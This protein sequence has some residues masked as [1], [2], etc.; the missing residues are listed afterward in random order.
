MEITSSKG[1]YYQQLESDFKID[2]ISFIIALL[3][4][5]GFG[6]LAL[7]FT[8]DLYQDDRLDLFFIFMFLIFFGSILVCISI[9]IKQN[10]NYKPLT[11]EFDGIHFSHI[12][13]KPILFS[14][15]FAIDW[16]DPGEGNRD[17]H[18]FLIIVTNDNDSYIVGKRKKRF[19]H[20][21]ISDIEKF[22][23][24][25]SSKTNKQILEADNKKT[26]K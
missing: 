11:I 2:R 6:I 24:V 19:V 3:I 8:I 12:H 20:Q 18:G 13:N 25:L 7:A 21:R 22:A 26:K 9:F 1:K 16:F 10:I 5:I 17:P 23:D 4:L 14:D 15:I